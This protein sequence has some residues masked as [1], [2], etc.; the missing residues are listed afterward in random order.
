MSSAHLPLLGTSILF[1]VCT[2]HFHSTPH[3]VAVTGTPPN[4]RKLFQNQTPDPF[5]QGQGTSPAWEG[6]IGDVRLL[7]GESSVLCILVAA[8]SPTCSVLIVI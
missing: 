6:A 5:W 1:P 3:H 7:R 8:L 2:N 4:L